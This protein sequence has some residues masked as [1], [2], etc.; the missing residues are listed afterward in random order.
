MEQRGFSFWLDLTNPSRDQKEIQEAGYNAFDRAR[1]CG[2]RR[3]ISM[4]ACGTAVLRRLYV[5]SGTT[6]H[7][8]TTH[9]LALSVLWAGL[10]L[11]AELSA[12]IDRWTSIGPAGGGGKVVYEPGNSK[13]VYLEGPR[14]RSEDGGS[15]WSR[16]DTL[17][18]ETEPTCLAIDPT[19][20]DVLY[21][22]LYEYE[23]GLGV[24]KSTD[25]GRTWTYVN[26]GLTDLFV[27]SL[28]IDPLM[29]ARLY[30]ATGDGV[31]RSENGGGSW[32]TSGEGNPLS[33]RWQDRTRPRQPRYGVP[34][35]RPL[36]CLQDQ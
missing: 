5:S 16:I 34:Y 29:P 23:G 2:R 10:L 25:G 30:A 9:L 14:Y 36:R 28:A 3:R 26:E 15:S 17:P 22:G 13:V 21:A 33:G 20:P 24:I 32:V 8:G 11:P 4:S 12:G 18:P 19:D 35:R 27:P 7:R 1:W 31:Y 6:A